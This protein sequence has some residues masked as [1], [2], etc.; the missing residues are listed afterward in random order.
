M[1][2]QIKSI[3]QQIVQQ[4]T[5][6][7]DAL[8]I[9]NVYGQVKDKTTGNDNTTLNLLVTWVNTNTMILYPVICPRNSKGKFIVLP[10][11][12]VSQMW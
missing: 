11:G 7:N 12:W 3:Y 4:Q 5:K 6:S 2:K 1:T 10:D 8:E 9:N